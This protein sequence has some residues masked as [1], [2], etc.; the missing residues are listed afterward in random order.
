MFLCLFLCLFFFFLETLKTLFLLIIHIHIQI[1]CSFIFKQRYSSFQRNEP[2]SL[3][4]T[5]EIVAAY[6]EMKPEDVALQT[7]LNAL[8]FFAIS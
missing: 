4:V 3:P 8:K 7:T 1:Y 2:S 5:L 6:L